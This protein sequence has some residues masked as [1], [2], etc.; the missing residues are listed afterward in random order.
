MAVTG[1]WI[2]ADAVGKLK[3][4]SVLLAFWKVDGEHTGKQLGA[5]M[6]EIIQQAAMMVALKALFLKHNI[7][8]DA[9]ERQI[10][11][12]PHIVNLAAKRFLKQAIKMDLSNLD[13]ANKLNEDNLTYAQALCDNPVNAVIRP[14]NG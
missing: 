13:E 9:E 7:K 2:E 1:H 8:F 10:H 5:I 4:R 3:M 12:F 6:M 11:C 14:E